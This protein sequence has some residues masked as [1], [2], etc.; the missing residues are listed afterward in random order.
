M[1]CN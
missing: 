1:A